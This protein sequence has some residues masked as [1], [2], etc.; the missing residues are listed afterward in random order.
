MGKYSSYYVHKL[1]SRKGQPWQGRLKWK[2]DKGKWKETTKVF[3]EAKGK[4]EAMRLTKEWFDEMN[5]IAEA[6]SLPKEKTLAEVCQD[7]LDYQ[8]A[9]N[10]I[11]NSTY[12]M[13]KDNLRRN[14]IPLIGNIGFKS[15]DRNALIYWHTEMA[16]RGCSQR[17]IYC[18]YIIIAKT[19]NY[20]KS[21]GEIGINP[22]DLVKIK[23]DYGPKITY[24]TPDGNKKFIRS[25]YSE[26][27]L[28][29]IRL[30][31]FL[32][33]YYTGLR[34]GEICGLRWRDIDFEANTITVSSAVGL[35]EGGSYTKNPKNKSSFRTF[36]MISQVREVLLNAKPDPCSGAWFVVGD[37]TNF[38][39]PST[40]SRYFKSFVV[41]YDIRD[42]FGVL[43]SLHCL[44]HNWATYAVKS[45]VDISAVS[46]IMGHADT[47]LT[48]NCYSSA[49][50]E[51]VALAAKNIGTTFEEFDLDL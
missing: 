27:G 47:T 46:E 18:N 16:K 24:M 7:Y 12:H 2:D 40:L 43:I 28:T 49:T 13:H 8:L 26:Y 31:A 11:E 17:Y 37:K 29:D 23:K 1:T 51:G 21:I 14:I 35:G 15:L 34:R 25:V 19:Y 30:V 3:P 38:L 6:S 39:A 48:L 4:K 44:R 33:A 41:A 36:P 42:A 10:E 20:Y 45:G 22:C 9:S 50:K 5:A 32:L